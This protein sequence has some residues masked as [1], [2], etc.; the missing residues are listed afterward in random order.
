MIKVQATREVQ[1]RTQPSR[2]TYVLAENTKPS[3]LPHAFFVFLAGVAVY[4]KSFLPTELAAAPQPKRR[5]TEETDKSGSTG[6]DSEE[7]GASA[8][9]EGKQEPESDSENVVPL[10]PKK[11]LP[12]EAVNN[13]LANDSRP[14]DFSR[15]GSLGRPDQGSASNDNQRGGPP[16]VAKAP[17]DEV[18]R[19]GGG[20]G[21]GDGND[22]GGR[23]HDDPRFN[24]PNR[25]NPDL[26]ANRA[27]KLA[28]PVRLQDLVGC[29]AYL[30]PLL[31]LL[32][33]ATDADGDTL[34]PIQ[35]EA[36]TG[37]LTPVEG[38]GWMF[39]PER[40][41][42]GEVALKYQISDGT[43][44]IEQ[45]A[46][47]NVVEA[48]PILGTEGD[49]NLLGTRCGELIDG[50]GGDDNIDAREGN[51]AILAG[52]GHDHVVAGAGND[53]IYGGA[54]DD[55]V[56]AGPG[57]DVVF[58]GPGNDR[59]FG[60]DGDDTIHG[61]QGDDRISG[62]AGGDILIG[63]DGDDKIH[64]GAGDDTLDGGE[65]NDE[66]HG[67]EEQDALIGGPG[68]DTMRG[69]A[70]NDTLYGSDG[71]D[72][73]HGGEEQDALI[74]GAGDDTMRGD[75]G[76]DSLDGGEGNDELHGGGDQD[77]LLAGDGNDQLFGGDGDDLLSDGAGADEVR[78]GDGDDHV[79]AAADGNADSFSGDAG[80][81]TIDYSSAFLDIMVD[82][83]AGTAQGTDIGRDLIEGFER[84]IGGQGD[85]H[86][87]AANMSAIMT[88]GEGDD[89]FE[90]QRSDDDDHQPDLVRKI[91]DFTVGDRIIAA[92][93]EIRYR[94]GEDMADEVED[95]F[96]DIY[97]SEN[98]DQYPIRFRFEQLDDKER[99]FVD[100]HDRED[101][102]DFYSIELDGRHELQF[103]VAVS[104]PEH[105]S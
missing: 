91:T 31:A 48:P 52:D 1:Q 28:G 26:M 17:V 96:D 68:D 35:L 14:I 60:E 88:G 24:P 75:A 69:D 66:L 29:S 71:N 87:T 25:S 16:S 40:G 53:V 12:Q 4:L 89:T 54:G 85:D 58:G 83:G 100:V 65:G 73:L 13:F 20:G 34:K 36:S 101:S 38:G 105:V 33:G 18:A 39:T 37:T 10:T 45:E 99:T 94:D 63:G 78:G 15:G 64:G 56:L 49:D 74:G 93:Y 79:V 6:G 57:N 103:T 62:G 104:I 86:L 84:I 47:F 23:R 82:V 102:E 27:P 76:N 8:V 77:I 2:E 21:G 80:E 92:R 50:R 61:E 42:L 11:L 41:W 22:E 44:S 19:R 70:G 46:F 51:D 90:F 67:G 3:L 32:A 43:T 72:E 59:L 95:L 98:T 97:L 55:V 9:N 5:P 81:D 7:L 30:I